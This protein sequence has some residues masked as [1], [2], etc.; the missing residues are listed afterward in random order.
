MLK[1]NNRWNNTIRKM[2]GSAP[3]RRRWGQVDEDIDKITNRMSYKKNRNINLSQG[4]SNKYALQHP[5]HF[6]RNVSCV[7]N[8]VLKSKT[9]LRR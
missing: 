3:S 2:N 9:A 1:Y 8:L 7:Q 6:F 5:N 4:V